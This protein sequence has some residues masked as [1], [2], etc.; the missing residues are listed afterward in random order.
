MIY[1]N[2]IIRNGKLAL[3]AVTDDVSVSQD[4]TELMTYFRLVGSLANSS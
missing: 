3:I 2:N 4:Q 1:N